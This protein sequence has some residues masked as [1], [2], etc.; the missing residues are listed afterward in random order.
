MN[1]NIS[2][3]ALALTLG[4]AAL[5]TDAQA[6]P[7]SCFSMR[8]LE[9][10]RP[11]GDQRIYARVNLNQVYRLDL[12]F[13]CPALRDQE[14][15]VLVPA[16][17]EDNICGPLDLDLRA[18]EVGGGSTPCMIK[19]ITKLTAAEAAALPPKVKP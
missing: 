7:R 4:V 3:I 5:A 9:S 17:G 14:G 8:Q 6:A 1:R 16:G 19:S 15:I 12:A 18:R 10:T 11:D 13:R 2:I